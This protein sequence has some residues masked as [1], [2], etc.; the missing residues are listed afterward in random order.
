MNPRILDIQTQVIDLHQSGNC[1]S[2]FAAVSS[3]ASKLDLS[4]SVVYDCVSFIPEYA[5]ET[6]PSLPGAVL[7][8][9]G[10]WNDS[11]SGFV[12]VGTLLFIVSAVLAILYVLT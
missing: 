1:P 8:D 10:Y 6:Y 4:E 11:E 3:V 7:D 2:F 5:D 9:D 12:S